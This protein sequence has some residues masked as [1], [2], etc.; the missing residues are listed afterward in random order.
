AVSAGHGATG[1]RDRN[2]RCKP[3]F[4]ASDRSVSPK[5]RQRVR[6]SLAGA[7]ATARRSRARRPDAVRQPG[8]E[9]AKDSNSQGI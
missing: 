7:P 8:A 4:H 6:R 1:R 5:P 9:G 2:G 3:D